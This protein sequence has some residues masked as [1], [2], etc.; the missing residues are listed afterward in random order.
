MYTPCTP[1]CWSVW[2]QRCTPEESSWENAAGSPE[3]HGQGGHSGNFPKVN[4][5]DERQLKD[6]L[7]CG[8]VKE[9]YKVKLRIC[10]PWQTG[11][12]GISERIRCTCWKWRNI[13]GHTESYTFSHEYFKDHLSTVY[14]EWCVK[15]NTSTFNDWSE[16]SAEL[17]KP[18]K[19]LSELWW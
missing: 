3:W 16:S 14:N 4:Q 1:M 17:N 9:C 12:A 5:W 13:M 18:W 11:K 8:T 19:K 7:Y 10:I 15:L 6:K 2:F